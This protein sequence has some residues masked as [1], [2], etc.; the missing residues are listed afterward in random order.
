MYGNRE[1]SAVTGGGPAASPA[2]EGRGRKPS[3][4]AVEQSD[5]PIVPGKPS[6]NDPSTMQ[7]VATDGRRWWREGS[8]TKGNQFKADRVCTQRQRWRKKIRKSPPTGG[9]K[10]VQRS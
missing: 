8:L 6:N 4:H 9:Q 1:S 3:M 7:S 2:G 5:R 10:P